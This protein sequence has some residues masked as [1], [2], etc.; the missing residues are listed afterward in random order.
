MGFDG[1]NLVKGTKMYV[2]LGVI[3]ACWKL[4]LFPQRTSASGKCSYYELKIWR[5]TKN[6]RKEMINE[7]RYRDK[8]SD[9][10][11]VENHGLWSPDSGKFQG[12]FAWFVW[13]FLH[14]MLILSVREQTELYSLTGH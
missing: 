7:M 12:L 5:K 6:A 11:T 14:L 8:G 3:L 10:K 1:D 4:P 13:M 2:Q 9:V